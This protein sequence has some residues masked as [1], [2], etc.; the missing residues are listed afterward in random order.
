[1]STATAA[2]AAS[3]AK[4]GKNVICID[5]SDESDDEDSV[6]IVLKSH[7]DDRRVA[8]RAEA[9]DRQLKQVLIEIDDDN[10]NDGDDVIVA[11][12]FGEP[13]KIA[14]LWSPEEVRLQDPEEANDRMLALLLQEELDQEE[15]TQRKKRRREA[16][17]CEANE[18]AIARLLDEEYR[19][20]DDMLRKEEAAMMDTLEGKA[21]KFV[22][23][24][25]QTHERIQSGN[26]Q[27]QPQ[28]HAAAAAVAANAT[29]AADQT[30]LLAID[31]LVNLAM[32]MLEKKEDFQKGRRS[33]YIDL[34]FHYTSSTNLDSIRTEGLLNRKERD[35]RKVKAHTFN[36][37]SLGEGI[38]TCDD[39]AGSSGYG[40][41]GLM[42]ARLKGK[43]G[44]H[45]QAQINSVVAGNVTV[46]RECSQC[47]AI[48]TF[49]T[50][51]SAGIGTTVLPAPPSPATIPSKVL[52]IYQKEFQMIIDQF[53][54]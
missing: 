31:D 16:E 10:D 1:M 48:L 18:E 47:L 39:A 9:Q 30:S 13:K 25:R 15:T 41:T 4:R 27:Q 50:A 42:V 8:R 2:A 14:A 26:L 35:S 43:T 37:S 33:T 29:A 40:D 23:A 7:S 51:W 38:Y 28:Q 11:S 32:R 52:S 17:S 19:L 44:S 45:G 46:L 22:E 12:D 54:A 34:G 36:G 53:F 3:V 21:W 49:P 5:S 6:A 20:E 24:L